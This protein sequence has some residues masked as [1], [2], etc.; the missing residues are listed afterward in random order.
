MLKIHISGRS[1]S[2]LAKQSRVPADAS[3]SREM[4]EAL[5]VEISIQLP[6][7]DGKP[8]TNF[9]TNFLSA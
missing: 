6:S 2:S 9:V 7:Y 8:I 3:T 1:S 5:H 4:R